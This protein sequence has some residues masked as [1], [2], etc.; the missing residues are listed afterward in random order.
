[1]T[2]AHAAP[3]PG[4]EPGPDWDARYAAAEGGLFG[5]APN[6]WLRMVLARPEVTPRSA[7]LLAD[8]DGRNGTWL[9]A[10]GLTVTAVDVSAEA[11]RRAEARDRAAGTAAE[12]IAADLTGW[13][14]GPRRW[15][16]AALLYLQG[17]AALRREGLVRSAAALAPGGWLALEGFA[18]LPGVE[19][20]GPGAARPGVRWRL[21]EALGWVPGLEVVEALAGHVL[22]DEGTTHRGLAQVIRLLLRAPG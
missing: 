18:V 6:Q 2:D 4:P 11:T 1:M 14:P 7:L 19:I 21:E 8:G 5:E 22:L 17:P 9:A 20:A 15:D 16:M 12:R 3:H 10:R 13:D